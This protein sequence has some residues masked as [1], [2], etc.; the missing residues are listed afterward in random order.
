M[1]PP[2]GLSQR[3]RVAA[4]T[5]DLEKGAQD[6]TD[7]EKGAQDTT[8]L[9]TKAMPLSP[10]QIVAGTAKVILRPEPYP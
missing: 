8:D 5:T 4:D 7:L 6:T 9:K 2:G 1:R 3:N 10:L